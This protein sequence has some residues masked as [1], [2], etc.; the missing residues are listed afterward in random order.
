M[1]LT[2][3]IH[4]TKA[5][6]MDQLLKDII[7]SN[8]IF[9]IHLDL[10]NYYVRKSQLLKDAGKTTEAELSNLESLSFVGEFNQI[11]TNP[12]EK[13]GIYIIWGAPPD[14]QSLN[15]QSTSE[16]GFYHLWCLC[17]SATIPPIIKIHH[18]TILWECKKLWAGKKPELPKPID[19][20][21]L[22]INN[23]IDV[24]NWIKS[25]DIDP[26]L[27]GM[28]LT[29]YLNIS[30]F[31]ASIIGRDNLMTKIRTV[32]QDNSTILIDTA[33]HWALALVELEL[34]LASN[35]KVRNE[36]VVSNERLTEIEIEIDSIYQ[37]LKHKN[38]IMNLKEAI[39]IKSRLDKIIGKVSDAKD[40]FNRKGDACS[41]YAKKADSGLASHVY[42]K[43]AA[44]YYQSAGNQEK[45]RISLEEAR[46]AIEKADENGEF[47][48]IRVELKVDEKDIK[49]AIEPFFRGINNPAET[50]FRISQRLFATS[51]EKT[52]SNVTEKP[53]KS[54]VSQLFPTIPMVDDRSLSSLAPDTL[55]QDLYESKKSLMHEIEIASALYLV[56][57]I[58][59]TIEDFELSEVHILTAFGQSP[60]I[61]REDIPFLEAAVNRFIQE[62]YLSFIHVLLPRIEQIIRRLLKAA[63]AKITTLEG[64]ALKEKTLGQ[65]IRSAYADDILPK[66]FALFFQ[67]TLTEEWGYNLRNRMAHGLLKQDE[68]SFKT[69]VRVL[70]IALVVTGLRLISN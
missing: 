60:F 10:Q 50:L 58:R 33:P 56:E 42:W 3:K 37:S 39:D 27:K 11:L 18:L 59:K 41:E 5:E 22:L 32:L 67:A 47:K 20:A 8:D 63:G 13:Y 14:N 55:E 70:H 2:F 53:T 28:E 54:L 1:D 40:I 44:T 68:C 43:E 62:D 57:I 38:D 35:K 15:W 17:N 29:R 65:L 31:L 36:T 30:V 23:L 49:K 69:A 7:N 4:Q 19:V 9:K 6:E 16:E 21:V 25:L 61:D 26:L 52:T 34:H 48:E 45:L 12:R 24:A 46:K 66:S 64:G 51:L